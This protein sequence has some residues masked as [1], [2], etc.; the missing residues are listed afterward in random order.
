MKHRKIPESLVY[1]P[2]TCWYKVTVS[3]L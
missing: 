3:I 2:E 1:L